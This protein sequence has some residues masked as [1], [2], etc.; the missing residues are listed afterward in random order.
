MFDWIKRYLPKRLYWRAALILVL[1]V[2]LLQL[3]VSFVFIQ[4]HFDGVT[5]QLTNA[6]V[7]ELGYVHGLL[8][9][10]QPDA[11][12]ALAQGLGITV[13]RTENPQIDETRRFYDL[14]GLVVLREL[15]A[16]PSIRAIDLPNDSRVNLVMQVG[17]TTDEIRY[18]DIGFSRRR[19]S[20]TNPHQ[21][22]VNM[23]FFGVLFTVIA[24]FYLRNQL[25]PITRL[26]AA[27]EAFGRGQSVPYRPS[28]AVEVRAAGQSFLDMRARIDR[29]IE[30]RTLIL[31][32]ISHDLRTPLTRLKL[33][34]SFLDP[35]TRA[36]LEQDVEDMRVLL[37]EFLIFAKTLGDDQTDAETIDLR[38]FLDEVSEDVQ[39]MGYQINI[40]PIDGMPQAQF[41]K[42]AIKRAL[43]NVI[44]NAFRY[45]KTVELS[46]VVR[47]KYL[48]F[49]VQDDG[50]GI[51]EHDYAEALKPF[52][53]LD[54]S[55]NQNRGTG[56]GLG[57]P[58]TADIARAHGGRLELGRSATLGGLSAKIVLGQ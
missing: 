21:L 1:P 57:L 30:Q 23:V 40:L 22:I 9:N 51:D 54:P 50:P 34:L 39:R 19:V 10:N 13:T 32:G 12:I 6:V 49:V 20:A 55:R 3:L 43:E 37:D 5:E 38:A 35:Q 4:R 42:T 18:Y 45:A 53:R 47:P 29:H 52:S 26:A 46:V 8:D 48:A 31:S 2:F 27:A 17:S 36:P 41:R 16:L 15:Q 11:A 7:T 44:N 58:I 25:R 33:G 24:F 56:V 14:T 28:G